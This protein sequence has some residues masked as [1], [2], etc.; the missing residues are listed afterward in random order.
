MQYYFR[1]TLMLFLAGCA[2]VPLG[3]MLKFS[4]FDKKDFIALEPHAIKAKL[5]VDEPVKIDI[6]KVDLT[7]DAETQQQRRSYNFPLSLIEQVTVPAN[8]GWL[9]SNAAKTEYTFKLST[10]STLNFKDLQG[11]LTTHEGWKFS[12]SINSGFE[13]VPVE[14]DAINFSML[15]KLRKNEN[16][17]AILENATLDIK[18][19]E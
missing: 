16:Y 10:E 7:L 1:L 13:Q 19:E 2:S 5:I 15:L 6:E 11:T 9:Y 3:T 12:F 14:V 4:S 8:A 17:T 18:R